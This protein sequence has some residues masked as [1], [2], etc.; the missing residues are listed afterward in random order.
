[1]RKRILTTILISFSMY[2]VASS[3]NQELAAALRQ[4]N[5]VEA[6]LIRAEKQANADKRAY[7]KRSWFGY[8]LALQDVRIMKSGI[9]NY[10]NPPRVQPRN[11]LT[12]RTLTGEYEHL[13]KD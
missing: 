7:E 3:E 6:A 11:P 2:A 9:S 4:L 1:M 8:K 10:L 13:R 12:L 5:A